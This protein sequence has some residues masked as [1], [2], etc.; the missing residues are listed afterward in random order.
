MGNTPEIWEKHWNELKEKKV[1]F[2]HLL[3]LY[4]KYVIAPSV[5]YYLDKHFNKEGVYSE[6]GVGTGQTLQRV[7]KD[8][9]KFY[10]VDFSRKAL[11]EARKIEQ[12]D[13]CILADI[14]NLPFGNKSID[15]I[16][17]L[18]IMEHFEAEE[19]DSVLLEFRRVLKPK[20]KAIMF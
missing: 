10:A 15:G 12:F 9:Q 5:K 17:N 19:L 4:R 7:R 2:G 3:Q 1:F 16:W 13:K 8:K 14:R 18:G 11:E 6:C 20:G